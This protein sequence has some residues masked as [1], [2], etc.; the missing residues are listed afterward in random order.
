MAEVLLVRQLLRHLPGGHRVKRVFGRVLN[1]PPIRAL[2]VVPFVTI[3]Q[4][5]TPQLQVWERPRGGGGRGALLNTT[6]RIQ[7]ENS[8]LNAF[9]LSPLHTFPHT[10]FHTLQAILAPLGLQCRGYG[11]DT[12]RGSP[13]SSQ[14]TEYAPQLNPWP[15]DVPCHPITSGLPTASQCAAHLWS[16]AHPDVL[17]TTY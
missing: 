12:D 2:L 11:G 10:L 15:T 13:L 14:V 5:K 1:P 8:A 6:F 3:V 7:S 17:R 4:E 16:H 9:I